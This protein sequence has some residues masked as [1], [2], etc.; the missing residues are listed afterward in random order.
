MN[1]LFPF[2]GV[3]LG[4]LITGVITLFVSRR[5]NKRSKELVSEGISVELAK[6]RIEPYAALMSAMCSLSRQAFSAD[7]DDDSRKKRAADG[8]AIFKDAIYGRVGI[9]ASYETREVLVCARYY[10]CMIYSNQLK[11]LATMENA[12]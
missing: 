8:A 12:I 10:S 3:I 11:C 6:A 4:A 2:L 7:E 9:L 1:L 5:A